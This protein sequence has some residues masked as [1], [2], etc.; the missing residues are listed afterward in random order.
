MITQ[1]M[2][3]LIPS[4]VRIPQYDQFS[5]WRRDKKQVP[6]NHIR[7]DCGVYALKI[8]EYLLLG[9]C[10]DGITD[11]NIQ[12]LRVRV[13]AKIFDEAPERMPA[14]FLETWLAFS[15]IC[16]CLLGF[17]AC[18]FTKYWSF[19][20]DNQN[21]VCMNLWNWMHGVN[22]RLNR[23]NDWLIIAQ[24]VLWLSYRRLIWCLAELF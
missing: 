6:Q 7:G 22:Y 18:D 14:R 5:F 15:N 16:S 3:E 1:M 13:A 17:L 24:F 11:A 10:F 9:V 20:I 8:L 4:K 2:N 19:R 12:V 21:Y 23:C